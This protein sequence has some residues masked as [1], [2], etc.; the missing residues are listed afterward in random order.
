MG[1]PDT[2]IAIALSL[3]PMHLLL[4]DPQLVLIP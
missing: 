1:T 3:N 4:N 2:L